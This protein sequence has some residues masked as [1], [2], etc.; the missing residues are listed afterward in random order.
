MTLPQK[1]GP[2]DWAR[3]DR[4]LCECYHLTPAEIG[5]LTLA[6]IATLCMPDE[7]GPPGGRAM[8][9]EEIAEDIRRARAMTPAQRLESARRRRDG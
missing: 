8:T 3:I 7:K 6:E 2:V 9:D 5:R 1:A 4:R